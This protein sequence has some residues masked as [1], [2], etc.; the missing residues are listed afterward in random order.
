MPEVGHDDLQPRE[1]IS[2]IVEE[3]WI[4]ILERHIS[5]LCRRGV[6]DQRNAPLLSLAV[7]ARRRRRH[8]IEL[9]VN[10]T[11]L[12]ALQAK[13]LNASLKLL[14]RSRQGRMDGFST[15]VGVTMDGVVM[16]NVTFDADPDPVAGP[17]DFDPGTRRR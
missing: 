14:E 12:E 8:R 16:T 11:Q 2:D 15:G 10:R 5:G 1:S 6:K 9:L 4:R 7:D 3:K 17:I 13:L